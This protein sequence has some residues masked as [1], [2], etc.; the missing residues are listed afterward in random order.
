MKGCDGVSGALDQVICFEDT[1]EPHVAFSRNISESVT[2]LETGY[3]SNQQYGSVF[4]LSGHFN[5]DGCAIY[6]YISIMI[7]MLFITTFQI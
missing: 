6:D 3:V 1:S 2:S 5:Y 7:D 4:V